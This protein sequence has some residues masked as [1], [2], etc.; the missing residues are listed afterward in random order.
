MDAYRHLHFM[1]KTPIRGLITNHQTFSELHN[2]LFCILEQAV[3]TA[4]TGHIAA[5]NGRFS[6]G[7]LRTVARSSGLLCCAFASMEDCGY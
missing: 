5:R 7:D 2:I 6:R 4:E 1:S 3:L